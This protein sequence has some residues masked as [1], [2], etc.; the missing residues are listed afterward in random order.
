MLTNR[1]S[2][3][4]LPPNRI[5]S[6]QPQSKHLSATQAPRTSIL[7]PS[8]TTTTTEPVLQSRT[9]SLLTSTT[10]SLPGHR[11]LRTLGAVHGTTSAVRK[12]TKSFIKNIA[13]SFSGAWGEAKSVTG[14][15]YQ[16]RDQAIDRMVKEGVALGAN[17][18]VGLV[19]RESEVCGCVVVSVS[20]TACWVERVGER[21]DE[22]DGG[23]KRD[24]A[25]DGSEDPFR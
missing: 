1:R 21:G 10:P 20:G 13:A 5:P 15:I 3:M 4:M 23:W 2:T 16:L 11:L 7:F 22:R 17:A 9:P 14:L 25:Q 24:S 12:D 8:T 19:V 6:W 18:I